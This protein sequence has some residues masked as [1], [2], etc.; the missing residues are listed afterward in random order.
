MTAARI[1]PTATL[2]PDGR[3]LIAGGTHN[4]IVLASAEAYDPASGTFTPTGDLAV[5]RFGHTATL[6][7]DGRVLIAGGDPGGERGT[8]S[9]ELFR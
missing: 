6:L 4:G 9:A 7:L 8:A 2:L 5:A 3:V 1:R